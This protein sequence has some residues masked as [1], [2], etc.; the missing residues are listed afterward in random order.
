MEEYFKNY[1]SPYLSCSDPGADEALFAVIAGECH[2]LIIGKCDLFP[3]SYCCILIEKCL[4]FRIENQANGTLAV[5]DSESLCTYCL[6]SVSISFCVK[7]R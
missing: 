6:G 7:R 3:A 4:F 2:P 5:I 1:H